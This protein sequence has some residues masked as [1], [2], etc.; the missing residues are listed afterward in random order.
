MG[1]KEG[2]ITKKVF[3]FPIYVSLAVSA[4]SFFYG[5][6]YNETYVEG[7]EFTFGNLILGLFSSLL[8]GFMAVFVPATIIS[9][10]YFYF[11]KDKSQ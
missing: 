11:K 2:F 1:N 3:K 8:V 6:L 10:V 5:Y 4:L 7:L 9:I